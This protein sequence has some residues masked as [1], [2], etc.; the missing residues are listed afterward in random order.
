MF[1][2]FVMR[3][4]Y[5]VCS[6]NTTRR[7][8]VGRQNLSFFSFFRLWRI[9]ENRFAAFLAALFF[10]RA[11]SAKELIFLGNILLARRT[12][13]FSRIHPWAQ[14]F[15]TKHRPLL[16]VSYSKNSVSIFIS[17]SQ[18]KTIRGKRRIVFM[19]VPRGWIEHPTPASSGPRS[20]TELPRQKCFNKL[21]ASKAF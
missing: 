3:K 4:E 16:V 7:R 15:F 6:K 8:V 14:V 1:C 20:T 19:P 5:H 12:K 21:S 2:I 13:W 9:L 18:R 10:M 11:D 17:Y